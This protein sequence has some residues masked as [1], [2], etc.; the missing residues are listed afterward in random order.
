M[1]VLGAKMMPDQ[2]NERLELPSD[3]NSARVLVDYRQLMFS[4]VGSGN[5]TIFRMP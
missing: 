4:G 3:K 2:N 1:Q 5:K